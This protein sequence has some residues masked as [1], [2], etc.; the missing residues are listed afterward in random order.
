MKRYQPNS[1]R[2]E[3]IPMSL[4]ILEH[5]KDIQ[6]YIYFF[7]VNGYPF[8][9]TKSANLNFVTDH[10]CKSRSTV[11]IK[12]VLDMVLET[13]DA[14]GFNLTIIRGENGFTVAKFKDY[15]LPIIVEIYG[16]DEHVD[17]I[18]RVIRVMKERCSCITHSI[19]YIYYTK[20]TVQ[21]FI[22]CVVKWINAFPSKKIIPSTMSPAMIVEV[23]VNP[24]FNHKRITFG[25]YAMVYTGTKNNMKRRSVPAIALN[26]SNE[27]GGH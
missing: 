19:P 27:H 9:A 5:H 24:K 20:L 23:K 6:L 11:Q 15:L 4:P 22:A 3:H 2:I 14:R 1:D 21:S 7:F 25:S 17:I 13:Y 18:E 10:P 12:T 16:K 26:E 8:L